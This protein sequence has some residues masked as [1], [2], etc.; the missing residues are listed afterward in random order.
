MYIYCFVASFFVMLSIY[1][2]NISL[3]VSDLIHSAW[4]WF[5]RCCM[6]AVRKENLLL[7]SPCNA[8]ISLCE[9]R[10]VLEQALLFRNIAHRRL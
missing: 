5:K 2:C 10:D 1:D 6:A 4:T 9:S 7:R 3:F 8:V